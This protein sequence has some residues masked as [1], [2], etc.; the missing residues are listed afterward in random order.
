MR[1]VSNKTYRGNQSTH[2]LFNNFF[3]E[4]R[5][6]C[7]IM[8]KNMVEKGRPQTT[9]WRMR[10]ACLMIK[11][12]NTHSEYVIFITF[13]MQQWLHERPSVLRDSILLVLL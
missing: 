3:F 12:T 2:F 5:A 8:C 4:N 1:N 6:F 9:I 13:S 11:A 7:E 10:I